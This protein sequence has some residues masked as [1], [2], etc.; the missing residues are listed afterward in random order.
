MSD[1]HLMTPCGACGTLFVNPASRDQI[2]SSD[3]GFMYRRIRLDLEASADLGCPLC[4]SLVRQD[5]RYPSEW[6]KN[7][8]HQL[9]KSHGTQRVSYPPADEELVFGIRAK[10]PGCTHI[11]IRA[12]SGVNFGNMNVVFL[13]FTPSGETLGSSPIFSLPFSAH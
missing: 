5:L 1:I 11:L 4:E 12:I 10:S 6:P 2:L 13:A 8:H 9:R 3:S 7:F